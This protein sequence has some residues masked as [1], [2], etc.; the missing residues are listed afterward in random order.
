MFHIVMESN[1]STFNLHILFKVWKML[2][3]LQPG[4]FRS[5]WGPGL[6]GVGGHDEVRE[7]TLPA[8]VSKGAAS[9]QSEENQTWPPGWFV[10]HVSASP[11][12]PEAPAHTWPGTKGNWMEGGPRCGLGI[13]KPQRCLQRLILSPGEEKGTQHRLAFG[14]SRLRLTDSFESYERSEYQIICWRDKKTK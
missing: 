11:W 14:N 2:F 12:C 10:L 13:L 9:M 8:A 1:P 7:R 3:Q 4:A 6:R 5:P